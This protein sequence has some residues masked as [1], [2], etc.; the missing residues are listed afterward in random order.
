M[1][2]GFPGAVWIILSWPGSC[3]SRGWGGHFLGSWCWLSGGIRGIIVAAVGRG[4][5]G[6]SLGPVS[7]WWPLPGGCVLL[8]LLMG[9]MGAVARGVGVG[10]SWGSWCW[11]SGG[12]RGI[13]VAAVGG[14]YTGVSLGPVSMWWPLPG[15]CVLLHL[16]IGCISLDLGVAIGVMVFGLA[17]GLLASFLIMGMSWIGGSV[18]ICSL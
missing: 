10:V 18:F 14:G 7:M 6:V 1:V 8:H 9:L 2:L 16:L 15:G 5:M 13:I 3:G 12:I 17:G 4:C 11:L